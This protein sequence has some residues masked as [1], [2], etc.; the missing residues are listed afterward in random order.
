MNF[1]FTFF[2]GGLVG[3]CVAVG[4]EVVDGV[5]PLVLPSSMM[6]LSTKK[7]FVAFKRNPMTA[8]SWLFGLN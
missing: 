4:G 8:T 3:G 5:V 1:E 6:S 2:V 7:G